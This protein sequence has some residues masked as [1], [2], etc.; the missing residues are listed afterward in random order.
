MDMVASCT[1][2]RSIIKLL[3]NNL[4]SLSFCLP[5]ATYGGPVALAQDVA[6]MRG[7]TAVRLGTIT[8]TADA[9]SQTLSA[10]DLPSTVDIVGGDQIETEN[11]D[12]SIGLMKKVPGLYFGDWNQGVVSG[13]FSLRGFDTNAHPPVTLVV[14]GIPHLFNT[15]GE[16]DFQ[17]FFPLEIERMELVKGTND[18]RYGLGNVTGSLNMFTKRGWDMT[19]VR[20]LAGDYNTKDAQMLT[21]HNSG[22]FSQTYFIG[23]RRTDG[24]R[25]HSELLK[26]AISGKWFYTSDDKRL[27]AGIIA[28]TFS[29]DANASGYISVEEAE[30]PA[31]SPEYSE[32]DGG[33]QDNNHIGLHVD[34]ALTEAMDLSFKAFTQDRERVRW[35]RFSLAGGQQERLSDDRN[36]GVIA[37]LAWRNSDIPGFDRV[38]FDFGFDYTRH[39]NLD[40]RYATVNRV[41][42]NITRDWD[43]EWNAMGF[44]A[45]ADGEVN[46]WLRL[47]AGIRS[48]SFSGDF[49][50]RI[51]GQS[52]D[53]LDLKNI[54]QP[55]V[56]AVVTPSDDYSIYANWGRTFRLPALPD[57]FRQDAAGNLIPPIFQESDN[58]GWE[59]G[60]K[61]T[62]IDMLTVRVSY[63]EMKATNEI[64]AGADGTRINGGATDRS[65][66]DVS[67][68]ADIHSWVKLWAAYS[69]VEAV[70]VTPA[71]G[72]ENRIGQELELVPEYTAKVGIDVA[73]PSG[74]SANLWM[75]IVDDYYPL[76][77]N[78]DD[79][80]RELGGYEVAHMALGY[81]ITPTI[82]AGLDIRNVFDKD[83]LSWAWDHQVGIMPGQPR[84]Y[85]GWVRFEF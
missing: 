58:D 85:Y 23:L 15:G 32:A 31:F 29:M 81:K 19:Q 18:P 83:Y 50:N 74:L 11:V 78:W 39:S 9:L 5:F 62:P 64:V 35:A 75:D 4:L 17:P 14:D 53:M 44:F 51:V 21:G 43:Y 56:G 82:A 84:S 69:Q 13:T 72:L 2:F 73:H 42:Q 38:R 34:Y 7:D 46:D 68:S 48:D 67:L 54:V 59:V 20:L 1:S 10:T 8:A 25:E 41:R 66:Y 65:G 49:T 71:P 63:W 28:R 70:F 36:H 47:I 45:Q 33:V 3:K 76:L 6:G 27:S 30:D 80:D 22:N 55:K 52:S 61:V 40:Q 60:I 12:F 77:A 37:T 79:R 24:F 26:G 57:L 16:P